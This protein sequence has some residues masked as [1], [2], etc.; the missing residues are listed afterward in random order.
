MTDLTQDYQNVPLKR[1]NANF[2]GRV[3]LTVF[4][5]LALLTAC[6]DRPT[7]TAITNVTV[8]DAVNGVRENQTVVFDGDEII[9][10]RPAGEKISV[11]KSIDATGKYLIPG[12][13]DFHVHL[14]YDD[15]FDETMPALF[16]SYGITS[17]RD[18]GGLMRKILPVVDAMRAE[19]AIAPRVFFAGPL[20][21]GRFVVYDGNDR[22]E[23]G[24]QNATPQQARETIANLKGQGVDFIK[25]YEMVSADVFQAMVE[26]ANE[27]ALPIDSHVPLSMRASIAGPSVDSIEHLRNI[28]MDCASNSAELHETRLERLK[29]P[30][31]L[32]GFELR[33]SLH[34]LQRLPAIENYDEER[35]D[36]TIDALA[37]TMMVPTLRMNS[38]N[39]AP[40]F[41]K[42]DWQDALARIPNEVRQDWAVSAVQLATNPSEE[43]NRFAEWSLFLV[44]RM[45]AAGVP[46]S[47][48]TDTP[49][50]LSVPGFSLHSELEFLV[51]AGLSPLD[52]LKAATVRP[53]EY[54][55]LQNKMGTID[56]GRVADLVLLD[57]NP[58]ENIANTRSV[59]AVVTK[60][61]FMTSN[62]LSALLEATSATTP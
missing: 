20:L 26:T 52:A 54:F 4:L 33:S 62:D 42:G 59:S 7:G 29:N 31:G 40:S 28:E 53:A 32:S 13:W 6:Q 38:F 51:Q 55:S 30:E 47:A 48:G 17:V 35:C 18:T 21:D 12:L 11:S 50:F 2:I 23:I 61:R 3:G 1:P 56:V 16:L 24:V 46:I 19:N 8:I 57:A 41:R 45:H 10:V 60:G 43:F 27:L 37:S 34:S 25:I 49:I 22:P 58:L 36:R 5:I 14:A 9:A 15:R 39:L 44:K